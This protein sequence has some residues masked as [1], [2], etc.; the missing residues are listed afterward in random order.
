[1]CRRWTQCLAGPGGS[2]LGALGRPSGLGGADNP[3]TYYTLDET[4]LLQ[5][6]L[7]QTQ[8]VSAGAIWE[9]EEPYNC[10]PLGPGDELVFKP[11]ADFHGFSME[12][13]RFS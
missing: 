4:Q 10:F 1:M 11:C 12:I 2:A 3:V 6:F 7:A 9:S 13:H 5:G 8:A